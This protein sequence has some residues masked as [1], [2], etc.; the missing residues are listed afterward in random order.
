MNKLITTI[1]QIPEDL[2]VETNWKIYSTIMRNILSNA[3]KFTPKGGKN[4]IK[5][6]NISLDYTKVSI[7]DTG[8]GV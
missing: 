6:E 7:H 4:T 2:Y 3:I 5:A 8:V 1:N